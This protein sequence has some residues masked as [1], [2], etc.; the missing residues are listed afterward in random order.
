MSISPL[1]HIFPKTHAAH[2]TD[3]IVN[4]QKFSVVSEKPR[5][6][7]IKPPQSYGVPK[8]KFYAGILHTLQKR[9]AKEKSGHG[10]PDHINYY[11]HIDALFC[12]FYQNFNK[13][14]A[15]NVVAYDVLL[16]K[17]FFL[18]SLRGNT[19]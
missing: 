10:C 19:S 5:K 15:H 14:L 9:G 13:L 6:N 2:K 3:I 16:A 17:N 4:H 18:G 11:L 8:D 7:S 1:T 12:F